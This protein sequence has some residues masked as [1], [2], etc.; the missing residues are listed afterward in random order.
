MPGSHAG[1]CCLPAL[2]L[3]RPACL[4]RSE[5]YEVILVNSNPATIMT[6][7]GTADRT[8]VGPMTPELVEQILAKERPDAILPTMGGQTGLNLAKALSEVRPSAALARPLKACWP[9]LRLPRAPPSAEAASP[10]PAASHLSSPSSPTLPCSAAS[11]KSMA[12]S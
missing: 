12:W 11:L 6:D 2:L 3:T 1:L 5:G 4:C 7:P 9:F 8:Y 10:C